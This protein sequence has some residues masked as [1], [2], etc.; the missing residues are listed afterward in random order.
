VPITTKFRNSIQ[1]W[2]G[3]LDTIFLMIVNFSGHM[4]SSTNKSAHHGITDL[5]LSYTLITLLLYKV[6]VSWKYCNHIKCQDVYLI[7]KLYCCN[8]YII[9][10]LLYLSYLNLIFLHTISILNILD[11]LYHLQSLFHLILLLTNSLYKLYYKTMS[12]YW[13]RC[14][15]H[16]R[17]RQLR[18]PGTYILVDKLTK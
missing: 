5:L 8:T 3:I 10:S 2:H 13:N 18:I 11:L 1:K 15:T 16:L 17:N 12:N 9:Q 14:Y 4:I 7:I 6:T